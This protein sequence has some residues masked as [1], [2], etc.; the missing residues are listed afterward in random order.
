MKMALKKKVSSKLKFKLLGF[1]EKDFFEVSNSSN[2]FQ[3]MMTQYNKSMNHHIIFPNI[4][5]LIN[6]YRSEKI[7]SLSEREILKDDLGDDLRKFKQLQSITDSSKLILKNSNNKKI[8]IKKIKENKKNF[9]VTLQNFEKKGK[10][11]IP[12]NK[13]QQITSD[14]NP[15]RILF[16]RRNFFEKRNKRNENMTETIE[17]FENDTK[18]SL[19]KYYYKLDDITK[20]AINENQNL[21]SIY[22]K[23]INNFTLR[24]DKWKTIQEFKHPE[25]KKNK[26]D[27]KEFI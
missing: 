3:K 20:N 6:D 7:N 26:F 19:Y 25:L 24:F 27:N 10:I 16:R 9:L 18:T 12:D 23:N 13:K 1:K 17:S 2:Y 8:N 15:R 22:S 14:L 4:N 21:Y 11:L 5:S